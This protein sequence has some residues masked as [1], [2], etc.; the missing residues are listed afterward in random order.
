MK[1][2]PIDNVFSSKNSHKTSGES[3]GPAAQL[4]PLKPLKSW[5]ARYDHRYQSVALNN[6]RAVDVQSANKIAENP[7]G[8]ADAQS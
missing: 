6:L 3:R 4:Q 2:G 7:A 8:Y 5:L 1:E